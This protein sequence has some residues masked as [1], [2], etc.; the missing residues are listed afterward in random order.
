MKQLLTIAFLF[1]ITISFSNAQVIHIVGK[2]M[3]QSTLMPIPSLLISTSKTKTITDEQGNFKFSSYIGDTIIINDIDYLP[4]TYI[5]EQT[6]SSYYEINLS[7]NAKMKFKPKDPKKTRTTMGEIFAK[8]KKNNFYKSHDFTYSTYNKL[9]VN[10]DNEEQ[11]YNLLNYL[12]KFVPKR[13]FNFQYNPKHHIFLMESFTEKKY[14]DPVHQKETIHKSKVSGISRSTLFSFNSDYQFT[15]VYERHLFFN[16]TK[17]E[18]PLRKYGYSKYNYYISDTI[19]VGGQAKL[20]VKFYPKNKNLFDAIQG[21]FVWNVTE[22]YVEQ[23]HVLPLRENGLY[24]QLSQ[25]YIKDR[26]SNLFI[27]QLTITYI[28]SL[29]LDYRN[30]IINATAKTYM[31][32]FR[33]DSSL[34]LK[35]FDENVYEYTENY[36]PQ[37]DTLDWLDLRKE[38]FT[39]YDSSTFA[40]YENFGHIKNLEKVI[41]IGRTLYEGKIPIYQTNILLNKVFNYNKV[42][43]LR[44]GLGAETNDRFNK[45]YYANA[46]AGYGT[47]D[48]TYKYGGILGIR[49]YEPRKFWVKLGASNDLSEPGRV[50]HLFERQQYSS[51]S[52]RKYQLQLLDKVAKVHFWTYLNVH[53]YMLMGLHLS[54]EQTQPYYS[55]TYKGQSSN[56]VF[57]E[58]SIALNYAYGR[59]FIKYADKQFYF[60][61]KFPVLSVQVTKGMPVANVGFDYTKIDLKLSYNFWLLGKGNHNLQF[62]MGRAMGQLPYYK[63]YN[64]KGS[65]SNLYTTIYNSFETMSYNEFCSDRYISLFYNVYFGRLNRI[66]RFKPSFT[67]SHNMGWGN[68]TDRGLHRDVQFRTMENGYYESGFTLGDIVR[69]NLYGLKIG[70]G[71]SMYYRYGPYRYNNNVDNFVFKLATSFR[72]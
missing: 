44:L 61:D 6:P 1:V 32:N 9:V 55:Y 25:K 53:K 54:H 33:T 30:I 71:F 20:L 72:I 5:V 56:F 13:F 40:F 51:E 65:F 24:G 57:T 59:Q 4:F 36:H 35:K 60:R 8:N 70:L 52:F 2:A 10:T 34:H 58:A 38:S 63:L 62:N 42:E 17:Y 37:Y 21:A 19:V 64:S 27:P 31:Y 7:R 47:L 22:G 16:F 46:Y 48:H 26:S 15:S 49:L 12:K 66:G 14:M 28:R 50:E 45:K 67:L 3:D 41:N 11:N 43:G 29:A 69:Y 23:I 39:D 68:L 18:N